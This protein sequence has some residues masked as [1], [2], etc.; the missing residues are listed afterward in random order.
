MV[1]FCSHD[2]CRGRILDCAAGVAT[3]CQHRGLGCAYQFRRGA[4]DC[5]R[6]QR[7]LPASSSLPQAC[8]VA[9]HSSASGLRHYFQEY[10]VSD[11]L[12]CENIRQSSSKRTSCASMLLHS[13]MIIYICVLCRRHAVSKSTTE[14][15]SRHLR[16]VFGQ[17]H[18][19]ACL[20]ACENCS[21]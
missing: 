10:S 17:L 18:L 12:G 21:A 15:A 4:N 11:C 13:N 7:A 3:A 16:T 1:Q 9:F 6:A 20:S 8:A 14:C 19:F 5:G 2:I